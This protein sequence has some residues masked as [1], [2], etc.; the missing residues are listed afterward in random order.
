MDF[1]TLIGFMGG[2][3]IVFLAVVLSG[4]PVTFLNFPAIL[5]VVVGTLFVVTM[6]FSWAR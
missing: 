6:K 5:I 1:A 2:L 4:S 3:L